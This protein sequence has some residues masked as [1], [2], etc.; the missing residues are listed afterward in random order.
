MSE[1]KRNIFLHDTKEEIAYSSGR[2]QFGRSFPRRANPKQHALFIERQLRKC[3]EEAQSRKQV[4]A[5]RY[6]DGLYLEFSGEAGMELKTESL[7]NI[8]QGIRLLNIRMEED[9]TKATVYV[10]AEKTGFYL[11]KV[12]EYAE[13]LGKEGNPK[14][15]DLIRSIEDVREA[16]VESFWT[17]KKDKIPAS[18][19]VW[20]EVWLR[21][22]KGYQTDAEDN[23]NLSCQEL[24]IVKSNRRV[25]FPERMVFLAKANI[26]QLA[27][28]LKNCDYIAEFRLA[29]EP[30]PFFDK[31]SGKEQAEWANDL[32]GRIRTG[33]SAATVCLLDTGLA[34]EHPLIKPFL[35]Q[36]GVQAVE[37]N[38]LSSDHDGHG[39]EMAG[40]ALFKNLKDHLLSND[41]VYVPHKIE[42]VKILP[43]RGGNAPELYGSITE[44]AVALAELQNPNAERS[45]CMAVSAPEFT[46]GDGRPSSWSGVLD[47]LAAGTDSEV[48]DKRLILI[49]A[50]NVLPHEFEHGAY[51]DANKLHSVENPGQSWN[52]L[53]IGAYNNDI[54]ISD[55]S[56]SGFNPLADVGELSPYSSTSVTWDSSKWPIKPEVLFEGSNI[57]TNG[58]DYTECPDYSLLTTAKDHHRHL[59]SRIWA[60]SAATAQAAWMTSQIY[61]E[62]PNIWPE[63]VR[64]LMV[65]SARWTQKMRDQL[66][67]D[68]KK[69]SGRKN[70]VRSCGYGIPHLDLAIQC[71]D[72]SVNMVIEGEL[73]PYKKEGSRYT[74]NEMHLHTLPWPKDILEEIGEVDAELRVT[75]SYFIEPSPGEIGWRDKYRYAS[76]GLRF[77][78]INNNETK[79]DFIKRINAKAR[80]DDKHDR[81]DGSS[82]SERW[83]LGSKVRDVGSVHSD[84]MIISGVELSEINQI[85]VYPVIGW[86]RERG[87]LNHYND[88][89][90]YALIVTISTP[91]QEVDLYTP[92][93]NQ[94][95]TRVEIEVGS[96]KQVQSHE[97]QV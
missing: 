55:S 44:Q 96:V 89:I 36:G 25:V 47:S 14:N 35:V 12:E 42:S 50:G 45:I 3:Q 48:G 83:F 81:G 21:Y 28:L 37:E 71:M 73:Q 1:K 87:Y 53:T 17:D 59:F 60:T 23:F 75:L 86:W 51:P 24:G 85:A 94:I 27:G 97:S 16:V 69:Q 39:T 67:H 26:D 19:S 80:G 95:T 40:V 10:P 76:C 34:S 74:M 78:V 5:I 8:R 88:R 4:A 65:H 62:Y 84:H 93:V 82:G 66:C 31:L 61:A 91:K 58:T 70:L 63:T 7:E 29:P 43:P 13:S 57:A 11:K 41:T 9:V 77:D 18:A 32:I 52:A 46:D 56:F 33:D 92:I 49:S 54:T 79:N 15:N 68:E 22:I 38:W 2:T 72:N 90:R 6:K 20:C 30:V 64:G